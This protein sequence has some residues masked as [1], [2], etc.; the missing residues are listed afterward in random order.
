MII[1]QVVHQVLVQKVDHL[2]HRINNN[3]SIVCSTSNLNNMDK[4]TPTNYQLVFPK[5]PSESSIGANNPFVMNIHSAII[6]F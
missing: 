6:P 5:I 2:H 3:M 1:C 4:S